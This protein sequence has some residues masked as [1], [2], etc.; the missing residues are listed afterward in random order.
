MGSWKI[1]EMSF[2]RIA[3]ISASERHLVRVLV[4][5]GLRRSHAD[6]AE[7]LD[8]ARARGG[9]GEPLVQHED[10]DDLLAAA[11][12]RVQARHGL[13]EDHRD[14]LPPDR[15]HLGL[16]ERQEVAPAEADATAHDTARRRGDE[17]KDAQRG[18]ALA[19]PRLAHDRER[20][21]R[22]ER[23]RHPTTASVSPA[24]R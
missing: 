9:P 1:I 23:E 16:G 4:A 22:V 18:D 17:P 11:V 20:L 21:A 10:L 6:L 2:T 5:P 13:L 8:R 24:W 3:R 15:A 19:A 7:E 14:L 12:D